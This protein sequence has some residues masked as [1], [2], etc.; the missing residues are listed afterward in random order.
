MRIATPR[1]MHGSTSCSVGIRLERTGRFGVDRQREEK[2]AAL[3]LAALHAHVHGRRRAIFDRVLDQVFGKAQKFVAV[4]EHDHRL[5]GRETQ[6]DLVGTARGLAA[7][8]QG[9]AQSPGQR[10][11][12]KQRK[13][14]Q[15]QIPALEESARSRVQAAFSKLSQ[16]KTVIMIAH[17]LS[18]VAGADQIY[19]VEDGR[20]TESGKSQ[21]LL[22]KGGMFSRMWQDYQLAVQWKVAKEVQ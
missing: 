9:R 8:S 11:S 7:R 21:E 14:R 4:A 20:I 12:Q 18:T 2:D 6:I 1:S 19:V 10:Q 22:E 13:D 17:R 15:E 5:S 16:G 3:A